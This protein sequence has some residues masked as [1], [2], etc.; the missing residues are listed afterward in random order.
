[1]ANITNWSKEKSPVRARGLEQDQK[2]ALVTQSDIDLYPP[3]AQLLYN[4]L[5][6]SPT[7]ARMNSI[8]RLNRHVVSLQPHKQSHV[9]LFYCLGTYRSNHLMP[10]L[11]SISPVENTGLRLANKQ[12][13]DLSGRFDR[14]WVLF[15]LHVNSTGL[16]GR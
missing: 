10:L 14:F 5:N 2:L 9:E 7:V 13:A 12:K 4:R 1:M 3:R 16:S 15:Y 11:L 8:P 6:M